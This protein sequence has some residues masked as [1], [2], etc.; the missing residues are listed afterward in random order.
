MATNND[1]KNKTHLKL[2]RSQK[3]NIDLLNLVYVKMECTNIYCSI[4]LVLDHYR[5]KS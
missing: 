5:Y 4:F 2:I 1:F 3:K